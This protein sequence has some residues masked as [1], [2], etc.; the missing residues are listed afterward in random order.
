M[1]VKGLNNKQVGIAATRKVEEIATLVKKNGGIPSV[2]S[3]QGEQVFDDQTGEAN[4]S[5]LL[6][7]S[8]D[9]IILTTGIGAAS[10]ERVARKLHC[11]SDFIQK[12]GQTTLAI[13]GS[14]T[15]HWLKE[16]AISPTFVSKDG[17]ME[18]L[19]QTLANQPNRQGQRVY[20]QAYNQDDLQLQAA[21]EHLGYAVYLAKPYYYK[22]PDAEV[23]RELRD[24]IIHQSLDAVIFTSKTQVQNLFHSFSHEH[25]KQVI[26]AFN[27]HV[28]A[29]AVGKVTAQELR[30]NQIQ[31]VFY[32]TKP[33]M[34]RMV[35]EMNDYY[36]QQVVQ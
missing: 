10:L 14:K 7:G 22:Q 30:K 32:P 12:L 35:V 28:L 34:G 2:F 31:D 17:T 20:L 9:F 21:L 24:E 3:I 4:I 18:D 33:K 26:A 15:C 16:H 8:F 36:D 5:T 13:R 25:R 19:I 27:K 23:L 1:Q 6:S 11:F 29:A